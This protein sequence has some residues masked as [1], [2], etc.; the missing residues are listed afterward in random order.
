MTIGIASLRDREVPPAAP[1]ALSLIRLQSAREGTDDAEERR[2]S[3][4]L[5]LWPQEGC[6]GEG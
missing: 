5:V 4:Q 3:R 6:G 1:T 2:G